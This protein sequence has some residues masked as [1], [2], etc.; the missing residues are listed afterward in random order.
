[1]T[2]IGVEEESAEQPV[3]APQGAVPDEQLIAMLG[4][5]ARPQGLQ[6][7]GGGAGCCSG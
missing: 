7:T 5:R 3:Q 4:D 6:S 1:M 2:D